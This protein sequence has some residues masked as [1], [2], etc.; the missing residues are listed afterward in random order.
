MFKLSPKDGKFF[1][2]FIATAQ[3]THKTALML[4]GF[5]DNLGSPD[6]KLKGIEEME[7][8]CD[9]QVHEILEQLNRTF[10]TPIDREDVYLIAKE[11]DNITDYIESTAHRFVMFNV[12]E[13]T[14]EAKILGDLIVTC[15]NEMISLMEELKMMKVTKKLTEKIIQVNQIEDDGDTVFRRAVKEL[16]SGETPAIEVIKW[17]EIYEHLENTLD[18]CEDVANIVEGVVM[19]HA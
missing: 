19:K 5:M 3:I 17:R 8:K 10:I 11:M 14:R 16:F 2:L 13:A 7:H 12:K 6:S 9:K 1:D 18:A 15:T 4:R